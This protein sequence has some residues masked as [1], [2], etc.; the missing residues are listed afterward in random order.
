MEIAASTHNAKHPLGRWLKDL[1]SLGLDVL[2]IEYMKIPEAVRRSQRRLRVDRVER[3]KPDDI[4]AI[5]EVVQKGLMRVVGVEA[6]ALAFDD[7]QQLAVTERRVRRVI[8]LAYELKAGIVSFTPSLFRDRTVPLEAMADSCGRLTQYG[9]A[10]GIRLAVENGEE[11]SDKL[12]KTPGEL[13][14]LLRLVGSP[15]LGVC[16]DVS[17]AATYD[18]DVARFASAL[19]PQVFIVHV[20]DITR[21]LRF[22]NII[23]GLG[24]I[25]FPPFLRLFREMSVP[26]VIEIFS[27]YGAIDIFLCRKQI[28]KLLRHLDGENAS[29]TA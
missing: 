24:D 10:R 19:L 18:F 15:N 14:S 21:D 8:D 11:G 6:G 1:L 9:E 16:L 4:A 25:D 29:N 22:K 7:T 5:R 27:G 26:F 2:E 20:N 23:V 28:E 17:A 13:S 3:M 12:L